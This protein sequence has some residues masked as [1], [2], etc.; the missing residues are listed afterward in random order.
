[1]HFN[2]IK[3]QNNKNQTLRICEVKTAYYFNMHTYFIKS[4][5]PKLPTNFRPLPQTFHN[6]GMV[7]TE[8]IA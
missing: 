5:F 4:S 7:S 6:V 2:D 3:K 1:M 8:S